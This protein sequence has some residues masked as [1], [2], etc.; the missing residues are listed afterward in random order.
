MKVVTV[1]RG[2]VDYTWETPI[3]RW[4]VG[5]NKETWVAAAD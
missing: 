5:L 3:A 1:Y 2:A 4:A